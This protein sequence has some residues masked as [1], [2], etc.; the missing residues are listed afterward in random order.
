MIRLIILLTLIAYGTNAVASHITGGELMYA[1]MGPG[2]EPGTDKYRIT[3]RLFRDCF[4]TG[5]L[6][7]GEQVR[8]GIY[9]TENKFLL[10][11]LSLPLVSEVSTLAL[12]TTV[13]PCLIGSPR[14]C[15]QIAYY[16]NEIDLPRT[17]TGYTLVQ[18]ACCRIGGITNIANSNN[19]GAT[20]TTLIPGRTLAG[21]KNNSSPEFLLKDTALVCSSKSFR[22]PFTASDADGDSLSYTFA[23]ANGN[24][25]SNNQP[26][27]PF[28]QLIPVTYQGNYT[29]LSPLGDAV[30]IHPTTGIIS[31]K[32]PVTGRYVVAVNVQEW[33]NGKLINEH[34]KDFILSVQQCDF[35]SAELP[36]FRVIC[37][38]S[39]ATFENG[40]FSSLITGYKWDFGDPTTTTDVSTLAVPSYRYKDTG[41]YRVKLVVKGANGCIDSTE[42]N[43][44]IYPGFEV[45]FEVE[46]NCVKTNSLF[47]DKSFA[48]YGVINSWKWNFGDAQTGN[49]TS[50]MRSP[51]YRYANIGNFPVKLVASSSKGCVDS[52]VKTIEITDKPF[53]KLAFRDSVVCGYDT[54]QITAQGSGVFSWAPNTFITDA[55]TSSPTVFPPG[56]AMYVVTLTQNNCIGTDTV[57]IKK[58]HSISVSTNADTTICSGDQLQ[59]RAISPANYYTWSPAEA[60]VNPSSSHT[61]TQPVRSLSNYT[62]DARLGRCS[63][64][65][66][67]AVDVSPYPVANAGEDVNICGGKKVQL[68]G[69]VQADRF[70]WSPTNIMI[71]SGTLQPSVAP[72]RSMPFVLTAQY[73]M[74]CLKPVR[75][76]VMVR[77]Y[78]SPPVFAGNDTSFV[79]NQPMQL[80]ASGGVLYRWTPASAFSNPF[81]ANPFVTL[82]FGRDTL[83]ATLEVTDENGCIASDDI[84]ISKFRTGSTV[85]VPSG[86]TPNSDGK[87]DILRP[88]FAGIRQ[89][90]F[91]RVYNR[92]GELLFETKEHGRGWNG[93]VNGK[94]QSAGTYLFVIQAT[95]YT[96]QPVSQRGTVVLIR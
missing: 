20:Y 57:R 86:F 32:A 30:T 49:D 70:V 8:V 94:A 81:T 60:F 95:D 54:V 45:D 5:P 21:L 34:R 41:V 26:L 11:T 18:T 27:P 58:L 40:S 76:T 25:V 2:S 13:F 39:S 87:N 44:A 91:F 90:D 6:L 23:E 43:V 15:Y 78:A 29:G 72:S 71:N 4:S 67:F 38:D 66:S 89:L 17:E 31:G 61:L 64:T 82:P 85:F 28:L 47:E 42:A 88:I 84:V 46:A 24:V 10:Q 59:V 96:G 36:E 52:A 68:N 92:W 9:G 22:L 73:N 79:E 35:V 51:S 48:N 14:V 93:T 53:L 1:Y 12:N 65:A 69:T 37:D 19:T 33:R 83:H 75:D 77:V 7:Q 55:N 74:G 16:S 50:S 80:Q 62:V 56:D 63:A 3:L